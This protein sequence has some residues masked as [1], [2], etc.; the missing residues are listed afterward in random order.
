MAQAQI[1]KKTRTKSP[2]KPATEYQHMRRGFSQALKEQRKRIPVI[3][4][5][6]GMGLHVGEMFHI[7]LRK[8]VNVDTVLTQAEYID[9]L[10]L[11]EA[12]FISPLAAARY[13]IENDWYDKSGQK[14]TA[15]RDKVLSWTIAFY[16]IRPT[17]LKKANEWC[18]TEWATASRI[19]RVRRFAPSESDLAIVKG[20]VLFKEKRKRAAGSEASSEAPASKKR[21]VVAQSAVEIEG[22]S[23]SLADAILGSV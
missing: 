18:E 23:Q 10:P 4:S 21:K 5:Y 20:Q 3:C 9:Q 14:S 12:A 17:D 8:T 6:T 15:V 7:P 13:V 1:D 16:D 22:S 19:E 11:S 2:V